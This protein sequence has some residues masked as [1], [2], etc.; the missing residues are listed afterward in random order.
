MLSTS[1]PF[2]EGSLWIYEENEPPDV[3]GTIRRFL[4]VRG[5]Y[6]PC[7]GVTR[8]RQ[9]NSPEI[10]LIPIKRLALC[11]LVQYYT[12]KVINTLNPN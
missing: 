11:I 9:G 6:R 3:G 2:L 8:L 12:K 5:T 7:R 1:P 4:I 10:H